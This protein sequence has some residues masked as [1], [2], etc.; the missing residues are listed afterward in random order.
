MLIPITK[1]LQPVNIPE[2]SRAMAADVTAADARQWPR[3]SPSA[4][5]TRG[6]CRILGM[7]TWEHRRTSNVEIVLLQN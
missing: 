7:E 6:F 2:V 3:R 1:H 4:G 5:G